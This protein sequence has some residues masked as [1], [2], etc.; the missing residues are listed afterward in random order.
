M[1]D[2]KFYILYSEE[3]NKPFT[4]FENFCENNK[5]DFSIVESDSYKTRQFKIRVFP[6]EKLAQIEKDNV[7]NQ[8]TIN[9]N[10]CKESNID[11]E[12]TEENINLIKN[13]EIVE[14][15]NNIQNDIPF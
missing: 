8:I 6:S 13:L 10:Y 11:I 9:N 12:F 1:K 14:M 5:K 15:S 3:L 2:I 7:L 4:S